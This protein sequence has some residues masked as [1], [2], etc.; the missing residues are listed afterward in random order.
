MLKPQEVAER[1]W[2]LS[3]NEIIELPQ[4]IKDILVKDGLSELEALDIS[5][6]FLPL[7]RKAIAEKISEC[8]I[9]D[10]K[11][12]FQFSET[13]QNRL[14]GAANIGNL[15]FLTRISEDIV[16]LIKQ[17]NEI[18][19]YR[20]QMDHERIFELTQRDFQSQPALH[21]PVKTKTNLGDFIDALY[22]IVYEGS[23][24][25]KRI[26]KTISEIV[27]P[28]TPDKLKDDF[29][30]MEIKHLRTYFRH[31]VEQWK[32]PE[33]RM[34]I[35]SAI[36]SKYAGKMSLAEFDTSDFLRFQEALLKSLKNFLTVLKSVL[37]T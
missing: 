30:G 33:E 11:E 25:L 5:D 17:I 7:V 22:F 4:A 2:E 34:A 15:S 16:L 18:A 3:P 26:P 27:I 24:D 31:D 13:S 12:K 35:I 36:C 29:I 21:R 6:E 8:A 14:I 19:E 32:N 10:E 9:K 37:L 20:D 1:I 28:G 23:R